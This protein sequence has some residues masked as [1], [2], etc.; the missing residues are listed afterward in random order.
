MT[1]GTRRAVIHLDLA[2]GVPALTTTADGLYVVWWCGI[3]LGHVD[4]AR[5]TLPMPA[6]AAAD[7]M[8][9]TAVPAVLARLRMNAGPAGS[10]QS[11][12]PPILEPFPLKRLRQIEGAQRPLPSAPICSV[13]I[14]TRDRPEALAQCLRSLEHQRTRP[15]E[16]IVVDNAPT[17]EATRRLVEGQAGVRYV[18][19]PRAGLNIARNTGVRCSRGSIIAFTDDD[20]VLHEDWLGRLQE[21]FGEPH[22]AVVTGLVLAA[23]LETE[24]QVIFEKHWGFNRGYCRKD[25]GRDFFRSTRR[26][27]CPVWEIGAGASMAIRRTALEEVGSFDERLDV[28]AAG[29]NGDSEL[30]YRVLAAGGTCRYEPG[31]VAFHR[32]RR[33]ME[34]LQRQIY[35]Y[36][37]GFVVALLI[38]F[39]QTGEIGNLRHLFLTL[40]AWYVRLLVKGWRCGWTSRYAT[41][42]AE[43][44]GVWS[45]FGFYLRHQRLGQRRSQPS[46]AAT[47]RS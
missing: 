12:A 2:E 4:L 10:G 44:S 29:C 37:R 9:R 13:V 25:Y 32:H 26:C 23:E 41:I 15:L 46:E 5:D 45:G 39:E 27:G 36:M 8:A 20:V 16:I 17:T 42:R 3:P 11:A 7:L 40:P 33:E 18:T 21:A 19:E 35:H 30:W 14:C 6:T 28:G 38:Q 24:A 47:S 34:D 22:V 1:S 43:V 31:I